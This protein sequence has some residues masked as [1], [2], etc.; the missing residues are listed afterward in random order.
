LPNLD[1]TGND[2]WCFACGENNPI[3]LKLRFE[4]KNGEYI[5]RFTP[6]KDHQGYTGITHGGI[7]ATLLDESMARLPW[8]NGQNAVT[9]ELTVRYK[10]PAKIGEELT[11]IGRI[12]SENRRTISCSAEARNPEGRI[13]AEATARLVKV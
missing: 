9:A 4:E 8:A 7:L 2:G 11:V 5:T 6:E 1:L 3:G 10:L 12:I 13:V